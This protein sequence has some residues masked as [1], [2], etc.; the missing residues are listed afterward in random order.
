MA[1]QGVVE[2]LKV[3]N[4]LHKPQRFK[5]VIERK[6][7]DKSTELHGAEYVD[8]PALSSKVCVCVGGVRVHGAMCVD[9]PALSSKVWVYECVCGP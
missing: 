6:Q 8:V 7:C 4:W 1:K 9:V 3:S 5:V 2:V